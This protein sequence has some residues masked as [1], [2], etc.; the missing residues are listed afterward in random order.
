M[1]YCIIATFGKWINYQSQD[2]APQCSRSRVTFLHLYGIPDQWAMTMGHNLL[3]NNSLISPYNGI[4][5]TRWAA[6]ATARPLMAEAVSGENSRGEMP[7]VEVN[8]S[9]ERPL[10]VHPGL[11]VQEYCTIQSG[12]TLMSMSMSRRT[13]T[14]LPT[15]QCLFLPK[16]TSSRTRKESCD[17]VSRP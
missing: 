7:A 17:A 13:K 9:W 4:S 3:P 1:N 14:L 10:L 2:Q 16:A 6:L 15:S 5:N 11:K 8:Q 12:S